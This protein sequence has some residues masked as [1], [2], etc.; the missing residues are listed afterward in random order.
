M[1]S[2]V[3]F[4]RT[5]SQKLS[6]AFHSVHQLVLQVVWALKIHLNLSVRSPSHESVNMFFGDFVWL[7]LRIELLQLSLPMMRSNLIL[8]KSWIFSYREERFVDYHLSF[9]FLLGT[10]ESMLSTDHRTLMVVHQRWLSSTLYN[11]RIIQWSVFG[12]NRSRVKVETNVLQFSSPTDRSRNGMVS[13]LISLSLMSTTYLV[14]IWADSNAWQSA[15]TRLVAGNEIADVLSLFTHS[16]S[17]PTLTENSRTLPAHDDSRWITQ[18][19]R[20]LR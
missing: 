17:L 4:P 10:D 14:G 18:R 12:S 9:H 3:W 2:L 13:C 15:E 5:N 8:K 7:T 6:N 16:F 1:P 20:D 11:T 19:F